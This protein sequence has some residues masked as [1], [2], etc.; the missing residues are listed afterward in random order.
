MPGTKSSLHWR[1]RRENRRSG[2]SLNW[3]IELEIQPSRDCKLE[4]KRD[5]AEENRKDGMRREERCNLMRLQD[6]AAHERLRA[7]EW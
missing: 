6:F 4:R 2:R 5:A 3:E 1:D 7:T